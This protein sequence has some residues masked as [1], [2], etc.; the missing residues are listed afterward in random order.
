MP[1]PRPRK[2]TARPGAGAPRP[3]APRAAWP[4]LLAVLALTLAVYL[5]SLRNGFTNWDDNYYVTENPLIAGSSWKAI[6]TTPVAGNYHPLTIASLALNYRIS[7]LRPGSYHALNLLL[8]LANTAL[9][10]LFIY[11]LSGGRL[12]TSVVTSGFFGIHPMHVESV[13][14]I[15]ERKDVLYTLFYLAGLIAYLRYL[16]RKRPPWLGAALVASVLSLASKPAAVVFPLTLLAIDYFRRRPMR[17]PVL[18]EKA[19][20][21]AVSIVGGLLTLH[22]QQ[23]AGAITEH[24]GAFEKLLFACYGTVMYLGKLLFPVQ[25][26]AIY[27]YPRIGGGGLGP[28]YYLALAAV[29]VI[30]PAALYLFRRNRVV[31]FGLAFFLINI[32]LVLQFFAIGGAVLAERYTYVPYIGLFFAIGWWLDEP[33]DRAPGAFP[34]RR[35]LAGLLV[36]LGLFSAIQTVRRVQVWRN[37]ETLWNDTIGKYPRRIADAYNNRGYY[38]YQQGG[39]FEE[40][41]ADFDQALALNADFH[42]AWVNKGM[43]LAALDRGDSAQICFERAL[44]IQPDDP[45]V[46]NDRGAIKF[47]NGDLTGAVSDYSRAIER[48]PGLRDAYTNRALAYIRMAEYEKS[49]EDSRRAIALAPGDPKNYLQHGSIGVAL[50]QLGRDRQAIP[51]YD[52]AIGSAPEGEPLLGGYYL[53]RSYSWQAL[54]DAARALRDAREASRLGAPI[55]PAYLRRIGG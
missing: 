8:H 34:L 40:A 9:V 39:R 11:M 5:P 36:L 31:L 29:V 50:H 45:D 24:W 33:R 28:E 17:L 51:E 20:F 42:R 55:D 43:T 21:F 16:E 37:A 10:F 1:G 3:P 14:W 22:A 53:Y 18:V 19:P 23:A 44:E 13:A 30:V 38:Y 26:S 35:V 27:P 32:V 7:G 41:L 48:K 54:G 15:A 6:L 25:L 52:E 2:K 12:W 49:I 46:L 47:R 4:W